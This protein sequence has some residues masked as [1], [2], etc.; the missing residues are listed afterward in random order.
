MLVVHGY[1]I[2]MWEPKLVD[3][4]NKIMS[5]A[6]MISKKCMPVLRCIDKECHKFYYTFRNRI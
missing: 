3:V 1:E 6:K 2:M 5:Y 4:Q